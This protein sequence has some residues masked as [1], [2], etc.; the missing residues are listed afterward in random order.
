M[1][2]VMTDQQFHI[3]IGMIV[4]LYLIN[5]IMVVAHRNHK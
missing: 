1:S 5:A 2:W 4:L 3:A